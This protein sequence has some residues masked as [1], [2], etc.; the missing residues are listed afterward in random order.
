MVEQ[1]AVKGSFLKEFRNVNE[2]NCWK[3]TAE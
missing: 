1:L 3:P 2:E